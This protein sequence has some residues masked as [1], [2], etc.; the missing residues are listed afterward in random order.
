MR[1]TPKTPIRSTNGTMYR[2]LY[3]PHATGP[4][5]FT[6]T[7]IDEDDYLQTETWR[8]IRERILVIAKYKCA[9]CGGFADQVHHLIYPEVWGME[10][11]EDLIPLCNSCHAKR[12]GR[13]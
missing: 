5:K 6:S 8:N 4:N 13:R 10:E 3:V 7:Q 1:P 12:H 2:T 11:L 9:D